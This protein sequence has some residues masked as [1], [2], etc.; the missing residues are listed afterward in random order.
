MKNI[1]E[2]LKLIREYLDTRNMEK[3]KELVNDLDSFDMAD[4]IDVMDP[5]K[6]VIVFRMLNKNKALEVFHNLEV[7]AQQQLLKAFT[8]DRTTELFQSLE[9]DDRVQLMEEL[10]A[11]V[12]KKLVSLLDE[13]DRKITMDLMGYPSESA[14]RIMT[15]KYVRVSKNMTILQATEKVREAG[16]ERER[17]AITD[18]YVTDDTRK[19]EGAITLKDLIMEEPKRLVK[20]V[21]NA[22]IRWVSTDTDQEDVARMLQDRDQFSIPVTDK[23]ERLV[24]IITIDDAMDILEEET[25]EDIYN[26][27]GLI[28]IA[29]TETDRSQ[30]LVSGSMVDVFKVRLPFLIVTLIGGLIAGALIEGFEEALEAIVAIAFFVPV[31]MDMGGNVGT[32][33]STIF[34]RALVLGQIDMSDFF[35]HWLREVKIGLSMGIIMGVVA[36][37]LGGLW[38]GWDLGL[39]VGTALAATMTIATALGFLIPY[40]LYK[41]GFDQAAG[42]DPFITTIKDISGLLI[43]FFLASTFLL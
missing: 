5:E 43:Y 38:Q 18:I 40:I 42:S 14:G 4:I 36:A 28:D 31:V 8:D 2:A 17:E 16:K 15:P 21:M 39:V 9:P 33:S 20:E 24:G 10:P 27:A 37:F 19:I 32:Q 1:L 23:E 29:S 41:S 3:L 25:T 13:E 30:R 12:V 7:N 22:D 34:S 11:V 35:K 26:K 6:Q